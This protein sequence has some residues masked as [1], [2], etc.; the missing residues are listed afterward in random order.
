ARHHVGFNVGVESVLIFLVGKRC[1]IGRWSGH[2]GLASIFTRFGSSLFSRSS[3]RRL[4]M[5]T[6]LSACV[7]ISFT[8]LS[9]SLTVQVGACVHA[10]RAVTQEVISRGPSIARITSKAVSDDAARARA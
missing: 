9:G 4:A 5:V 6:E 10:P 7:I 1:D 2:D 8:L 3:S